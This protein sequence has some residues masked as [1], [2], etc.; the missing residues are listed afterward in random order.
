MMKHH[1]VVLGFIFMLLQG[2]N[3]PDRPAMVKHYESFSSQYVDARHVDVWLPA[4]YDSTG[5]QRYSVLYMHDGQNLF[6][7]A[8]SYGGNE[9]MVDEMVSLL[10]GEGRIDSCIVV[11]IWNTPKRF[12]EYAPQ[13]PF[14]LLP[15]SAKVLARAE[16]QGDSTPLSD[17]YLRFVVEELKPFIDASF[18]TKPDRGHTFVMGSSMGGL[19]SLYALAEYPGVFGG[20]GC[21]STHWP[22]SLRNNSP[23]FTKTVIQYLEPRLE[24][25]RNSK[26]YFDYGTATLDAWYEPHQKMID[27]LFQAHGFTG[28]QYMSRKFEGAEHNEA[29]WAQRL[30]IPLTFLLG[31]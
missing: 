5:N 25:M 1:L 9:W 29:A 20:A 2:C 24:G 3:L 16:F 18:K 19:I 13:A 7:T 30:D 8:T 22:F 23:A 14:N 28:D 4:G 10:M 31:R 11:G 6:D 21:L 12:F 17:A 27:S 26:I 15:D